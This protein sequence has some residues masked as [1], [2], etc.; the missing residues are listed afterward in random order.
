M[1]DKIYL[2]RHLQ[3]REDL[4]NEIDRYDMLIKDS[5]LRGINMDGMPHGS[6]SGDNAF[7]S[8]LE[9]VETACHRIL[10]FFRQFRQEL[11]PPDN[12]RVITVLHNTI[13]I[14]FHIS[15]CPVFFV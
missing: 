4:K 7:Y 10:F 6:A 8:T 9:K 12:H 13:L 2:K 5:Q 15:I 11:L 14:Q 1:I 3:R